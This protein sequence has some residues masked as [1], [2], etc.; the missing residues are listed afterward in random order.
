MNIVIIG[1]G[2]IGQKRAKTLAGCR[3]VACVDHIQE[4][5]EALAR[6]F[7]G[8]VALTDWR[9]AISK[10]DVDIVIVA[11]LHATLTGIGLAA[12]QAGKHV[13]LEKPAGKRASELVPLIAAIEKSCG[14]ML[15]TEDVLALSSFNKALDIVGKYGQK[16]S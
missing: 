1:C 8:C 14:V 15:D 5:A 4:K 16:N 3:L 10:S 2:L 6:Q 11:T 13:L 9:D 12:V 7:P